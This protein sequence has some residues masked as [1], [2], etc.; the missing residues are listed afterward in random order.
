MTDGLFDPGFV[1]AALVGDGLGEGSGEVF[2]LH[3]H[4]TLDVA[5]AHLD[6]MGG[7]DSGS[8]SHRGDIGG[9]GDEGSGGSGGR[10]RRRHVDDYGNRRIEQ[11]LN[12]LLRRGK[13]S[14]G[15]IKL[16]NQGGGA[17]GEGLL[18][19][20]LDKLGRGRVYRAV[21]LD[22][23]NRLSG[24]GVRC[25]GCSRRGRRGGGSMAYDLQPTRLWPRRVA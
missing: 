20:I 15:G 2:D 4:R 22:Q 6:R 18:D 24:L 12:D 8:G 13:Q 23:V 21:N 9:D 10:S 5:A 25:S 16:D 19:R 1:T 17:I 14:T 11:S 3:A 7:A